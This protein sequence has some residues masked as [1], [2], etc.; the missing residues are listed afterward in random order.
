MKLL[1]L[2][3]LII[4]INCLFNISYIHAANNILSFTVKDGYL[5]PSGKFVGTYTSQLQANV[6]KIIGF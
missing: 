5:Q 6:I 3:L 2:N 1:Y 4:Y